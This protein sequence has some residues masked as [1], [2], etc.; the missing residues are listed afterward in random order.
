MIK[1]REAW[2]E[3]L[4]TSARLYKYPFLEQMLIYAQRPDATAC[5]SIEIWN[6]K[7]NCWVN[8]GAKGIALIDEQAIQP[9]LKYVYDVSDVHMARRIGRKPYLWQM[10]KEHIEVVAA[11]LEGIYG[12]TFKYTQFDKKIV[13]LSSQ[14]AKVCL[15]ETADNIVQFKKGS[16][17]EN[18]E[19]SV[20]KE[21]LLSILKDSIGYTICT[22]CNVD[23]TQMEP[24]S[25]QYIHEFNT[26]QVLAQLGESIS[27]QCKQVLMEIG[28]TI[29]AFNKENLNKT[30]AEQPNIYYNALKRESKNEDY[31]LDERGKEDGHQIQTKRRLPDTKHP[32][33]RGRGKALDQ[34]RTDE[35]DLSEGD[36]KRDVHSNAGRWQSAQASAGNTGTS[37]A[38]GGIAH[39]SDG[40]KDGDHRADEGDRSDALGTEN[41][42][43]SPNSRRNHT[44]RV[45]LQLNTE[46]KSDSVQQ[47]SDFLYPDS[48]Q[49]M[50][51]FPSMEE[52]IGTITLAHADDVFPS[53]LGSLISDKVVDQ[54]LLTG[55]GYRKSRL[56]IFSKYEKNL[57]NDA[58]ADFLKKEYRMGGKGFD[59]QGN[60]IC[61][62]YDSEGMRFSHGTTA[63]YAFERLISWNEIEERTRSLIE[64]GQYMEADEMDQAWV[65]EKS[66]LATKVYYF[67]RDEYGELPEELG[68]YGN[69][70]PKSIDILI[71][72]LTTIE[73]I[74]QIIACL[75]MARNKLNQGEVKSR[76][77]L[78]H[79]PA[80]IRIS[81]QEL[82]QER[83]V[84]PKAKN[85]QIL[86]EQFITQDEI[87]DMFTKGSNYEAS[88]SRIYEHFS[89]QHDDKEDI[90]FLK[91]EYGIGGSS[92]ALAGME[93][94]YVDYKGKGIRFLKG[95]I[96]EPYATM[97]LSWNKVAGRIRELIQTNRFFPPKRK[98]PYITYQQSQPGL[99][100][101]ERQTIEKPIPQDFMEEQKNV[102]PQKNNSDQRLSMNY[103][104][105]KNVDEKR[106]FSPKE[107][108]EDNI[109][110]IQTL[111][112]VEAEHRMATDEEQKILAKYVGWGGL[113]EAF[114]S[115][116]TSWAKEYQELKSI[117]EEGEYK[118]AKSSVLNAHYTSPEIIRSVYD[119]LARMGFAR[120]NILEPSMGIGNFFGAMPEKMRKSKLYGV[121]LDAITGRIAKQLYPQANI[122]IRGFEET[123]YSNDFFDLVIGNVPFGQYKV[124]DKAYAKYHFLVHD[125]F[126]IKALDKVRP[127]GIIA[128]ITSKGTM[129]KENPAARKYLAQRAEL[130]GAVRLP[131]T[132]F[133]D[134]AGTEATSDIL[135]LKKRDHIYAQEP[136]WIYLGENESGIRMNQYFIDHPKQVV[137]KM[138]MV[139]GPYGMEATCTA[140]TTISFPVQ[141]STAM[142]EI[143]GEIEM[144]GFDEIEEEDFLTEWAEKVIPADAQVKNH[145]YTIHDSRIYYRENSVM[146]L[147][148][149]SEAVVE[150]LKGMIQI[151][152]CTME[153]ITY[154]LENYGEGEIGAKQA[155][156][157][158]LYDEFAEKYGLL[159]SRANKRAFH[160]DA[161]YALLCSLE[162]LN[163]DGTLKG[164]A[165]MFSKRTIKKQEAITSV[166]TPAEAL[167]VSIREKACVDIGYMAS[168][169]GGSN[170]FE[171]IRTELQGVIFK[172]PLSD[173]KDHYSGWETGDEYLSGNVRE[174]LQIAKTFLENHPE[175]APNVSALEKIQPKELDATEI[176]VRLG[177]TW[178]NPE[179]INDFMREV[180]ETPKNFI[181]KKFIEVL[182]SDAASIWNVKGKKLDSG[183]ILVT[184]TYGTQRVN[185]YKILED[186]LNLKDARVYDTIYEDGKEKR[187][188]NKKETMLAVQK[189]E[190]IREAFKNWIFEDSQRREALCKKYNELFNSNRP[191]EYD[192][193]HLE[194]PGMSP[195]ITLEA[196]QKNAVARQLYGGN[197]LL[198]HCVG[199][200]KTFE[201]AA[202]AM[203]CKRL[204]LS[205][206][207][208]FVVPN[209]L[210]EQWGSDFLRLYPGANLLIANKKDFEPANRKK[211]CSKISTGEYDAVIIGHTQFE[212]IPLSKERQKESI[213]RQIEDIEQAIWEAKVEDGE[214]YT[215]KQMEKT[216]KSLESRLL[217]LNDA[218]G[219]DDV[220]TFEQLGVDRLFVDES[221]SYKNLFLYTKMRNVAGISQT[222]AKKSSDM[223]A[224]C[225]YIDELT[226]GKGVTFATGTPISNS[227]TE[228]YTIMRYLMYG[229]LQELGMSQFDSWAANFGETITAIE[230]APE[231]T[232]YR[233]KTRFA[234]FFNLPELISLFKETADIQTPDMLQLPVPEVEYHNE[235]TKPTEYQ[236][237]MVADL[238]ERAESVRNGLV[239][240]YEDNM[241]RITNDGR[242]LALDQRLINELLPDNS[243]AK[244]NACVRNALKIWKET[245]N[246]KSAQLI[247]SDLSTPKGDGSFSI[248]EDIKYKFIESGVPEQEIAFVHDANTEIKKALLF[249]KVRS[250]KIRFLLGST[251]KMGAGTNVQDKLAALHHLD[252][253]WRPSDIEQREGRI[254]RQGNEN[255]K[256]YIYRY[257]TEGT[258]DSYSWQLIEN[259][260]RFI[261]QIMTSKAAVRS[262]EDIDESTLTYA[263]IKALAT[264]NP[265]IKQ[266]MDL[267]IQVSRL[268][269]LKANYVSQRYR[270][271]DNIAKHYP[272]KISVTKE[273][274]AGFQEDIQTFHKHQ[275]ADFHMKVGENWFSDKKEAGTALI[276]CCRKAKDP[277]AVAEIG[278]YMG[279]QMLLKYDVFNSKFTIGF[280]G[281][282]THK[283]ELGADPSGNILRFHH[284]FENM[285]KELKKCEATIQDTRKQLEKAEIEVKKP[286]SQEQELKEKLEQLVELNALLNMEEKEDYITGLEEVLPGNE[287]G[288][289]I[290]E[291]TI[292]TAE[293]IK[294]QYKKPRKKGKS[295]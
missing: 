74:D 216:K 97:L 10:D 170:E 106:N 290:G 153:L 224:K 243:D 26:I 155:Q 246:K 99:S 229:K 294:E 164:K 139:S 159:N 81:L 47:L 260:Q 141:L 281:V 90:Q 291:V 114:D 37:R 36:Q 225:R 87:D 65:N 272:Y 93:N 217:K 107:R 29:L 213:E 169:L 54:V 77:R 264:G 268:K 120:G 69:N 131:N 227:V 45:D 39:R 118:A 258:F 173:H 191:R 70:V 130:L 124:A 182:Y 196:H 115:H 249:A 102:A 202:A 277:N 76:Y 109:E 129:D 244:V 214:H 221:H 278:E 230:L 58:M 6:R 23:F 91:K 46:E 89:Q 220:V 16:K 226:N 252:I 117:L 8:K 136:D 132:A 219:K 12:G 147:I 127:G 63:R 271:E 179:Y 14:I 167:A 61:V 30:V 193:S 20:L 209:H 84:F 289:E 172:N 104:F 203:E 228:L 121:E 105:E 3:Y 83:I 211:F 257:V 75:D 110:A 88:S 72:M 53:L 137:G 241:L 42:Q 145:S 157:N 254:I 163:E 176:E 288:L 183:N 9:R 165:D 192:G 126:L 177:A 234:R 57:N 27:K 223:F 64:N 140:A 265:Y 101:Q 275:D 186:T 146:H 162:K 198:A 134:N 33:G 175:F 199:A 40:K 50:S 158:T 273:L 261:S 285:E 82:K 251:P 1:N 111:K 171:R 279:F 197:S 174:K 113:S 262:C 116:K 149:E 22:R 247:F 119:T 210:T 284:S 150:R 79:T 142:S 34:I 282:L 17:L 189:Q 295:L 143:R 280:K 128:M 292:K 269:L 59:I 256:V 195:E 96:I 48:F 103:Y 138:E 185:A 287:D 286:F 62:W 160:Q 248:Y 133:K 237:D 38:E 25:F 100:M 125:Y 218:S 41:E 7:M 56:R 86:T 123:E 259:K 168:L 92:P 178:I 156:L 255:K 190:A 266:K 215:I 28:K 274:I 19:E 187:V 35:K 5:A 161:S 238:A 15:E 253:P 242:K 231:G 240:P 207:S 235:V 267:D 194:F 21:Y 71:E 206:K 43:Y 233:A 2:A 80:D 85:L 208:L 222:E 263:E 181:D 283:V 4:S 60:T 95:S 73:G 154:Q 67:F 166:D 52:Q 135:F 51:L 236:E 232:G 245:V 13:E 112:L 188:L 148:N 144:P 293:E 68:I 98:E 276:A 250:G 239:E 24:F 122:Q 66:E 151:R 108:F 11:K 32:D 31:F 18:M 184:V 152:N 204:G 55:S 270:L 49:Q 201:M 212:K 180:F 78:S 94:S 205:Q 44:E 200:G